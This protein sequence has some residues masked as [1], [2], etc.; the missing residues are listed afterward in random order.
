[1]DAAGEVATSWQM[2]NAWP[3]KYTAPDFNAAS[4]EV[5]VESVEIAHEGVTRTK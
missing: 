3:T 4:S 5:A 2:I 1:M